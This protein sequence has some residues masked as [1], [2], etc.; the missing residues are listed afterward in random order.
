MND[1]YSLLDYDYIM[2][3]GNDMYGV[4][5]E[6]TM[7]Q[8]LEKYILD[9][10]SLLAGIKAVAK[11]STVTCIFG[12]CT[13]ADDRLI[14]YKDGGTVEIRKKKYEAYDIYLGITQHSMVVVD[15]MSPRYLYEFSSDP[16][17]RNTDIQMV[18]N[19]I[20]LTDVGKCFCLTN[21]QSCEINKG[22]MGSVKCTVT[23]KN[24]DYFK[25]LLP[26]LGG[27]GRNMPHHTEYRDAIINRLS[28]S[29]T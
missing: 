12:Q 25:L 27:L 20:L 7:R 15:C 3:G 9:G 8:A 2:S 17:V 6:T 19:D 4:F 23:M 21:I 16:I 10:E 11:E 18:N 5:D 1:E 13:L 22:W 28:I 26:K 29:S 14:P 24:G